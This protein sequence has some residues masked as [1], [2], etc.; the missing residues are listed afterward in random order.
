LDYLN[1]FG[2]LFLIIPELALYMDDAL[3]RGGAVPALSKLRIQKN[4]RGA[5]GIGKGQKRA[6]WS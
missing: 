6:I 3:F 1:T 5:F 2:K 4:S